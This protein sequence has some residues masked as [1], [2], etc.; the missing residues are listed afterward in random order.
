MIDHLF[1]CSVGGLYI[2]M[3]GA[4]QELVQILVQN[5]L[6]TQ[7]QADD[8][9][10]QS[11]NLGE[12]VETLLLRKRLVSEED[13]LKARAKILNIPFISLANVA[14]LPEL[15]SFISEVVARKYILLPFDHNEKAN[16]LS[17]AMEDPLDTQVIEFLEKKTGKQIVPYMA[18]KDEITTAIHNLYTQNLGEDVASALKETAPS[19]IKTYEA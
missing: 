6:L 1:D 5:G 11:L 12:T 7:E 9:I 2:Y 8:I 17:V 13:V 14:I 16:T 4:A 3:P 19:Q 10:L 18:L 15:T